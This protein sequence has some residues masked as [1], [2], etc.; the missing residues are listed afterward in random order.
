MLVTRDSLVRAAI[1]IFQ[2]EGKPITPEN[3]YTYIHAHSWPVTLEEVIE[4]WDASMK[5]AYEDIKE[6]EALIN[7]IANEK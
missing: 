1:T 4:I 6:R 5:K 3:I 2:R 7:K